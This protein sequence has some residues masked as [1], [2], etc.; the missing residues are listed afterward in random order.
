MHTGWDCHIIRCF[1]EGGAPP[2]SPCPGTASGRPPGA[3]PCLSARTCACSRTGGIPHVGGGGAVQ[4]M[5]HRGRGKSQSE[6]VGV[7][8]TRRRVR[9]IAIVPT[10]PRV[11]VSPGAHQSPRPSASPPLP[12]L[13]F[14]AQLLV[15]PGRPLQPPLPASVARSLQHS[16]N[17]VCG[18][19]GRRCQ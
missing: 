9:Q 18:G 15:L 11:A 4:C 2:C 5:L 13:C 12:L 7:C 17:S 3:P 19:R 8:P 10:R 16:R 14:H 6:D 1:E